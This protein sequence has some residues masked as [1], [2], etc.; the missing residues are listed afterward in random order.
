MEKAVEVVAGFLGVI[1]PIAALDGIPQGVGVEHEARPRHDVGPVAGLVLL[2]EE[3]ALMLLGEKPLQRQLDSARAGAR[4]LSCAEPSRAGVRRPK[5]LLRL[6]LVPRRRAA[7]EEI[8]REQPPQG[9]VDTAEIPKIACDPP[10]R[11]RTPRRTRSRASRSA[12][13]GGRKHSM[14]RLDEL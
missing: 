13:L 14:R 6:C 7:L 8:E 10:L 3:E 12:A 2:Q 5:S 11:S 9:G 4:P 1:Q